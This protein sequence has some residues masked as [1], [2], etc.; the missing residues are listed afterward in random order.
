MGKFALIALIG[1]FILGCRTIEGGKTIELPKLA[2]G[3]RERPPSVER[4][5]EFRLE[6][7]QV[8]PLFTHTISLNMRSVPLR[9]VLFVIARD[10]GL[11]LILE[12]GVDP[13]RPV[14]LVLE[15]VKLKDALEAL[16][17]HRALFL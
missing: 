1:L 13:E 4:L 2:E 9:D 11:N 6:E 10:A 17:F 8:S 3:I 7:V 16:F 14:T 15:R 5:P 12:S